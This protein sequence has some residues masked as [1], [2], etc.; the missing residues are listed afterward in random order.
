[1]YLRSVSIP[2][3]LQE[4]SPRLHHARISSGNV[5]FDDFDSDASTMRSLVRYQR[6]VGESSHNQETVSFLSRVR[7]RCACHVISEGDYSSP[8]LYF[9]CLGSG[10]H[11]FYLSSGTI[12]SSL[13][14]P[15][16]SPKRVRQESFRISLPKRN[17]PHS[18]PRELIKS[19]SRE[20]VPRYMPREKFKV[21]GRA[22]LFSGPRACFTRV[23]P[24]SFPR[25]FP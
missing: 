24:E 3:W 25:E 11:I 17:S 22:P 20:Y 6:L 21:L 1:M 10:G 9:L 4:S 18:H 14:F 16:E 7:A 15:R 13:C 5:A 23:A 8:A 12:L 19:T 2:P